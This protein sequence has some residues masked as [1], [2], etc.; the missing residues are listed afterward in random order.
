MFTVL[1]FDG[2]KYMFT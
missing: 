1:Y 2:V